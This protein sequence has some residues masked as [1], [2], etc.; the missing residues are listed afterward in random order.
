MDFIE[1]VRISK[2]RAEA[3]LGAKAERPTAISSFGEILRVGV[4]EDASAERD[5]GF[6][7]C[8]FRLVGYNLIGGGF[9]ETILDSW[10]RTRRCSHRLGGASRHFEGRA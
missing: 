7:S 4:P 10:I 1:Q 2:K 5:E 6:M 3:G 9:H 8:Y